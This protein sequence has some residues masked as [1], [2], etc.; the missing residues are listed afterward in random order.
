VLGI[1]A[2]SLAPLVI[3]ATVVTPGGQPPLIAS[4]PNVPDGSL[5]WTASGAIGLQ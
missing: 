4:V 1:S 2:A 5:S 3:Q